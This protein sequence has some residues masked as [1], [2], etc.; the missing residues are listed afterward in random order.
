MVQAIVMSANR[1][2]DAFE[3]ADRFDID[4]KP[5]PSFGF[6]FSPHM[7]IG[8][9]IAKTEMQV[10]LNAVLDLLP[11]LRLAS[12][13]PA[14]GSPEPSC[15]APM[16]C[17]W[18]GIEGVPMKNPFQ[19]SRRR[20]LLAE[21][22]QHRF[23]S[24]CCPGCLS[25]P[26]RESG[27]A[28]SAWRPCR[29]RG[30]AVRTVTGAGAWPARGGS[31]RAGAAG[32]IGAAAVASAKPDGYSILFTLSSLST[33]PEQAEVNRQKPA[34]L[35]SQLKPVARISTDPLAIVVRA[36]SPLKTLSDL[37]SV[38]VRGPAR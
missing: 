13:R 12:A 25:E 2:E 27:G 26:A 36:D 16:K 33:L 34:F 23:Q 24:A 14:P 30:A 21:C 17:T 31:N 35:L 29:Q 28:F 3:Q 37:I 8:Q 19:M 38:R 1:D 5:K 11:N 10:A 7:C 9:F 4:R 18:C 15:A 20:W 6:G 22:G 32:A